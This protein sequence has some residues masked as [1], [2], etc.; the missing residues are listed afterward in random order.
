MYPRAIVCALV[1]SLG[2]DG[3]RYGGR[4]DATDTPSVAEA[5]VMVLV[6]F[7]VVWGGLGPLFG[8]CRPWSGWWMCR[9]SGKKWRE[10]SAQTSL[11]SFLSLAEAG[12][13]RVATM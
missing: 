6:R 12:S 7:G 11:S 13:N 3:D 4:I 9:L 2:G 8:G 10:K 1:S 5:F